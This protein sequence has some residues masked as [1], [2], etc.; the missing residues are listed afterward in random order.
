MPL[1]QRLLA[2]FSKRW[3]RIS[4]QLDQ[5]ELEMALEECGPRSSQLSKRHPSNLQIVIFWATMTILGSLL[6]ILITSHPQGA[7]VKAVSEQGV[8]HHAA[9][10]ESSAH[11]ARASTATVHRRD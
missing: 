6:W 1:L 2:R 7:A 3:A 4:Q 5:V 8:F 10:I 11:S 9:R